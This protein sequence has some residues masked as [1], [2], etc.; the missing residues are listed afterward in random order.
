MARESTPTGGEVGKRWEDIGM[1]GE[2]IP[3]QG[4]GGERCEDMGMN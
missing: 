2:S 1:T 3:I 4:E